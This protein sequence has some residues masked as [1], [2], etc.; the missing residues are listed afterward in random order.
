[1]LDDTDEVSDDEDDE[2][3]DD[4][5]M[6]VQMPHTQDVGQLSMNHP[7]DE[8]LVQVP[9]GV[10]DAL[11]HQQQASM[12]PMNDAHCHHQ[13]L[14]LNG[15]DI[16]VHQHPL[17]SQQPHGTPM[18]Q[19]FAQQSDDF[20][21]QDDQDGNNDPN[22]GFSVYGKMYFEGRVVLH[23]KQSGDSDLGVIGGGGGGMGFSSCGVPEPPK[24]HLHGCAFCRLRS[25]QEN[26]RSQKEAHRHTVKGVLFTFEDCI[27]VELY[28]EQIN[29]SISNPNGMLY[30]DY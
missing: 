5:E 16:A 8:G 11:V 1:V 12:I 2:E 10:Q 7:L 17:Q 25:P 19:I 6:S 14:S 23:L 22:S 27:I 9:G 3:V 21:A 15:S 18:E 26:L 4:E 29:G 30:V 13:K 28:P 24:P 20:D